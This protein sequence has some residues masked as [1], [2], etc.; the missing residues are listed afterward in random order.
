MKPKFDSI[1]NFFKQLVSSV[2]RLKSIAIMAVIAGVAGCVYFFYS[3]CLYNPNIVDEAVEILKQVWLSLLFSSLVMF[4]CTYL[5][6]KLSAKKKYIIQSC[7][8]V[9]SAGL[10]FLLVHFVKESSYMWMYYMGIVFALVAVTI[11]IFKPVDNSE[12]YYANVF[13]Y[14]LFSALLAFVGFLGAVLLLM[15]FNYLIHEVRDID[16]FIEVLV[17]IFFEIFYTIIFAFYFFEQRSKPSG[18]AF[19]IIIKNI[20][21]PVYLLLII[22]LYV[23]LIKSLITFELPSGQ[24]NWFVSSAS[25]IYMLLYFLLQEYKEEKIMKVFYKFGVIV[26]IPLILVQ[27][28]AFIIR[29][30]AYGFTGWR[31]S[32]LLFNIFSII[33]VIFTFIKKGEFV[34]FALP[35]LAGVILFGSVTPLNLI[36]MA[37]NSQYK[38]N[39][40]ILEKYGM[41]DG[42][43]LTDYD[44]QK[45]E[46]EITDEDRKE[47][48]ET[49]YYIRTVSEHKKPSY[50]S[51]KERGSYSRFDFEK[52]YKIK[53]E[54][55]KNKDSIDWKS[56]D[57]KFNIEGYSSFT[58]QQLKF[59]SKENPV[60]S[61][62]NYDLT[63][64]LLG[65][66]KE[67]KDPVYIKLDESHTAAIY[68]IGYTYD[69]DN[70]EFTYYRIEY[71]LLEK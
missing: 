50:I 1:K 54:D 32:S 70:K 26:L 37:F 5:T 36:D 23:Y 18:K 60:F 68:E 29:V 28:P 9:I 57:V 49:W 12:A 35:V 17:I 7:V 52:L 15:A 42:E 10:M 22:I 58:N 27:I 2:I 53:T 3:S 47:L 25:A 66:D 67:Q 24:I 14:G 40:A 55:Y 19:K 6:E 59:K 63:E 65:F 48:Y 31:Y 56:A 51:E 62:F 34:K 45:I 46:A 61:G 4:P 43:K 44:P 30:N 21:L 38:R 13:K 8:A 20:V 41:F 69:K 11:F 64:F 39:T 71:Y 33:F 16:V